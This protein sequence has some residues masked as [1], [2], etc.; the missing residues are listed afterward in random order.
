MPVELRSVRPHV[1]K[2]QVTVN[3]TVWV[4]GTKPGPLQ[5]Q[6]V[7]LAV[8]P[9]LQPQDWVCREEAQQEPGYTCFV[10][11]VSTTFCALLVW[12]VAAF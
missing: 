9:F 7:L 5:E 3:H 11:E 1:L 2:A 12:G 10:V 8:E 4:L 6:P